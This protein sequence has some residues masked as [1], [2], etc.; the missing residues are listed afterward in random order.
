MRQGRIL[1]TDLYKHYDNG[2]FDRLQFTDV[3]CHIGEISCVV[4]GCA[5]VSAVL[6]EN[7]RSL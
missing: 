1:S 4:P 7:E 5:D 3:G 2:L 6:A